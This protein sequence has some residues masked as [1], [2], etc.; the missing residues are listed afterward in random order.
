MIPPLI[1]RLNRIITFIKGCSGLIAFFTEQGPFRPNSDGS[2]TLNSYAWN[3]V[4]NMVFIESPTGVGFS[5]SSVPEDFNSNDDSTARDNYNLIQAFFVRFPEYSNTSMYL[6]SESYGGHYIPTLAKVVVDENKL[7]VN[8][9]LNLRGIAIGNPYTDVNS[10]IPAMMETLWGHQLIPMPIY[11]LYQKE[12]GISSQSNQC[13]QLEDSLMNSIGNINPYA[14][15]FEVCLSS[16]LNRQ[17]S[18]ILSKQMPILQQS[19]KNKNEQKLWFLNHLYSHLSKEKR[20]LLRV[21]EI[22]EYEPCEDDFTV[23]YLS[24]TAVKQAIHVKEDI[25]WSACSK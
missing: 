9:H 11:N 10:G 19:T 2:L 23:R 8:P 16:S 18:S 22:Q 7:K 1:H 24:D 14:L 4:S 20:K 13:A 5:Y 21:P 17:S 3:K 12:C 6:T 25:V 15:D